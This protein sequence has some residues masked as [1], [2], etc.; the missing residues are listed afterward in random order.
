M[1]DNILGGNQIFGGNN[2]VGFTRDENV[3][4]LGPNS[5]IYNEWVSFDPYGEGEETVTPVVHGTSAAMPLVIQGGVLDF[6][7]SFKTNYLIFNEAEVGDLVSTVRLTVRDTIY[8]LLAGSGEMPT[9]S[10]GAPFATVV[11]PLEDVKKSSSYS[12]DFG[13]DSG[14]YRGPS[15]S[16]DYF[17]DVPFK[18]NF[19]NN[20]VCA[21]SDK[22]L[23]NQAEPNIDVL[24]N[25][26]PVGYFAII[27]ADVTIGLTSM[28]NTMN[29][30]YAEDVADF[31]DPEDAYLALEVQ[32]L[33]NPVIRTCIPVG[34]PSDIIGWTVRTD[35][36]ISQDLA[37]DYQTILSGVNN[38]V[39]KVVGYLRSS[40]S[41]VETEPPKLLL[42]PEEIIE[43]REEIYFSYTDEEND[44]ALIRERFKFSLLDGKS[45]REIFGGAAFLGI[46]GFS[47]TI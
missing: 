41:F 24:L 6:K 5:L 12:F 43:Y 45:V 39:L 44:S 22:I 2:G 25:N 28:K 3:E 14:E 35:E 34:S 46:M 31:G 8:F 26:P 20:L 23:P 21:L 9:N 10:S 13:V 42:T 11:D 36:E 17:N 19:P 1:L 29:E 47:N 30:R 7:M 32:A 38:N 27:K 15:I 18:N 4:V 40:A 16:L 33:E 37:A